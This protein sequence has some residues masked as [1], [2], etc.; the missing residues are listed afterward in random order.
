MHCLHAMESAGGCGTTKHCP[1]CV[2]RNA[3]ES[4][5]QNKAV[6]QNKYKVKIQRNGDADD[7]HL[8][9][10]ASPFEYENDE[11]VLLAIDDI[12]EI[13]KSKRLL[14]ICASCKKIRNDQDY[15]ES[16]SDYLKKHEDI[17]FTHSI[18]PACA[19]KLYPHLGT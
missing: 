19:K 15:W 8:L 2:I 6:Y 3:V 1:D 5:K 12:T 10:S 9:V 7:V 17:E 13:I 4:A 11:F 18:C 14:P 16:V